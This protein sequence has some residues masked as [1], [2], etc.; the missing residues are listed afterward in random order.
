VVPQRAA[1]D[2]FLRQYFLHVH[3]MLPI[4]NEKDFWLSYNSVDNDVEYEMPM[5]VLQGI[6]FISSG[7]RGSIE[8]TEI[9]L[10]GIVCFVGND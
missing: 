10:T 8:K 5:L 9:M 1:L 7:V 6:L 4:L 3:P 2:D